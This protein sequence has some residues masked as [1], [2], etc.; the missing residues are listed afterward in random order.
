MV[1]GMIELHPLYHTTHGG[2]S[3]IHDIT[4]IIT[5]CYQVPDCCYH[6]P[7]IHVDVR[8]ASKL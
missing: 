7:A 3:S 8:A 2:I 4:I 1:S 5:Y 6:T